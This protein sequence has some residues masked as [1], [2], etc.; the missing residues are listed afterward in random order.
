MGGEA[1]VA[2]GGAVGASAGGESGAVSRYPGAGTLD[3]RD[4][5][6]PHGG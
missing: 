2:D 4:F 6:K 1:V 3:S 5:G